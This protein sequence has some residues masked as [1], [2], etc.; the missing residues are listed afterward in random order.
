[1]DFKVAGS[2]NGIT[3]FQ[4]D[5]KIQGISYEIMEKA[6]QQAKEGRLHILKIMNEA[7]A[8]PRGSISTYAPRILT[9][10]I[11]TD[12]IGAV[13]GPGGKVIQKMQKDFNVEINIEE[14]GTVSI[15]GQD[16]KLA[17]EAKEYIRYLTAEPEVG[18]IY[19]AR[20]VSIKEFGAFVEFLPGTQGLLHISQVDLKKIAKVSDV[21]KEGE[22]IRVKLIGIE[23]G[24][25]SLSRKVLL[26][27]KETTD[28]N[29]EVD[30]E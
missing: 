25:F 14:D 22:M 16:S 6:L 3:G 5:I 8:E 28:T 29:T 20:V 17:K 15:A 13:I 11:P 10:K 9:L 1:M 30:P 7:I 27:D 2:E 24:K 21:L 12:K 23:G 18:K 26:K 4:M 19:N